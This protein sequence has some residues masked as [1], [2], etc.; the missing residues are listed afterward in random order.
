MHKA[1]WDVVPQ[2]APASLPL[3]L[4]VKLTAFPFLQW[5]PPSHLGSLQMSFYT[6]L[7]YVLPT[8]PVAAEYLL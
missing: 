8:L 6:L 5:N 1:P 7:A 4:Q 3:W 2:P